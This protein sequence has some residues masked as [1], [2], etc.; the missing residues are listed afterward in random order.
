MLALIKKAANKIHRRKIFLVF[1]TSYILILV[2]AMLSYVLYYKRFEEKMLEN[3]KRISFSMLE[4]LKIDVDNKIQQADEFLNNMIF[5]KKLD[6]LLTDSQSVYTYKDLMGDLMAYTKSD[7]IYDYYIYFSKTDE[8]VTATLKSDAKFFYDNFYSYE[9]MNFKE[10]HNSLLHSHNKNRVVTAVRLNAYN[11]EKRAIIAITQPLPVSQS[12][13]TLGQ[14][15]ILI[16]QTKIREVV[17]KT[18]WISGAS[19]YI[20]DKNGKEI[21]SSKDSEPLPEDLRNME[22]PLNTIFDFNSGNDKVTVSYYISEKTGW[23]YVLLIPRSSYLTEINRIQVFAVIIFLICFM[24]GCI[25][26]YV[27]AYRNY[28]PIREIS[29]TINGMFSGSENRYNN[30]FDYW[31]EQCT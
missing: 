30:E 25:L 7:Y 13:D 23:R 31:C 26:A 12:N 27:L 22:Y 8:I 20:M 4:Q 2:L 21:L 29:E 19:V 18:N 17:D 16:D 5:N 1:L 11:S 14:A 24:S 15:V 10:W 6:I 3:E 28:R 9:G